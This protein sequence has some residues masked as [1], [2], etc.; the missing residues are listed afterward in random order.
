MGRTW[1][2]G[3]CDYPPDRRIPGPEETIGRRLVDKPV[4]PDINTIRERATAESLKTGMECLSRDGGVIPLGNDR[5]L[6]SAR[7]RD[8]DT[9]VVAASLG[10]G[11]GG[12]YCT[13][14]HE[15]QDACGHVTAALLYAS[16]NF[17]QI[18]RDEKRRQKSGASG[19]LDELSEK[20]LREFLSKE[21]LHDPELKKRFMVRF[22]RTETKRNVRADLD[23]AYYQMGDAG[24]YGGSIIFD[25]HMDA[26]R[27]AAEKGDHDEAIRICREVLEVIQE[28]MDKVDDSYSHYDTALTI[29]LNHMVD[30]MKL[31]R[32]DHRRKRRHI[33]YLRDRADMDEYGI[34]VTLEQTLAKICDTKEDRAYLKSLKA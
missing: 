29:A 20:Q 15:G 21:I 28:N 26:A 27:S 4:R 16:K 8:G 7:V 2:W 31:Q 13:C 14:P 10:Y 34:D 3:L 12:S 32:L 18:I 11:R 24:D 23:E 6:F 25:D 19:I 5:G 33:S 9:H 1:E 22:G 30:C 17:D